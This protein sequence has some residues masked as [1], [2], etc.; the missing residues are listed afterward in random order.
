MGPLG[1]KHRKVDIPEKFQEL[2]SVKAEQ[3]FFHY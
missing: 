3:S 2:L 1:C